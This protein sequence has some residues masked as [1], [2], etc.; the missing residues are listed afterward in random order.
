MICPPTFGMYEISAKLQAAKIIS[1][2]LMEKQ[3]FQLDIASITRCWTPA[4]KILFLCSPN[5]PTGGLI[6]KND[7]LLL[8]KRF[9][10][11]CLI[12][13]DEAYIEFSDRTSLSKY[14]N[15][16][17]NLIVLR[18]LSKAFGLAAARIGVVLTNSTIVNFLR[19]ILAP[20]PLSILSIKAALD[21]FQPDQLISV[22]NKIAIIKK[23]REKLTKELKML[24]IVEK[25]WPSQ[26]NF[27]LVKFKCNIEKICIEK[28]IILRNME[29]KMGINNIIRISIGK[30][31]DNAELLK[32]LMEIRK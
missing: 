3:E 17:D 26:A 15:D 1:V 25:I 29:Q 19:K 32:I 10:D 30:P 7:I 11:K 4:V 23:E 12:V 21:A 2:P 16:Y 6:D 20:Y 22:L 14:I 8:C 13:V 28:G 27:L 9:S 5:N 18:T 24:S 31:Q